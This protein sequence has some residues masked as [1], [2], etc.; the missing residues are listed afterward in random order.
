MAIEYLEKSA[1][2]GFA[3]AQNRLGIYYKES[4]SKNN[5]SAA[6]EWFRKAADQGDN[7]AKSKLI[8]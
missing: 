3:E 2:Q 1:T 6:V 8:K 7:E 4:S 5:L